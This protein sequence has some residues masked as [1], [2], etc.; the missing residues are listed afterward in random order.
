MKK[1]LLLL[2]GLL[3]LISCSKTDSIIGSRWVSV[4]KSP[5]ISIFFIDSS[6][7][8]FRFED[9]SHGEANWRFVD[10]KK[11]HIVFSRSYNEVV[12]HFILESSTSAYFYEDGRVSS[13]ITFIKK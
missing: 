2:I 4:D 11:T 12:K 5:E 13:G 7:V 10:E 8:E 1:Y 9:G 6:T 3:C